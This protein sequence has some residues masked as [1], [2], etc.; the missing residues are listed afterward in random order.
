[1]TNIAGDGGSRSSA[2]VKQGPPVPLSQFSLSPL[3][4]L[5]DLLSRYFP[6]ILSHIIF[7]DKKPAIEAQEKTVRALRFSNSHN[8]D[9]KPQKALQAS[10]YSPFVALEVLS[11]IFIKIKSLLYS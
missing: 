2:S 7:L 9:Q 8:D 4:L 6:F 10:N 1:M 5:Y 11:S 3:F